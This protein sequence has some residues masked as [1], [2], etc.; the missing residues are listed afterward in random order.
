MREPEQSS[1]WRRA[2]VDRWYASQ[3]H[4]G[5]ADTD[6]EPYVEAAA[7]AAV[8]VVLEGLREIA[9]EDGNLDDGMWY[10]RFNALLETCS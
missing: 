6:P 8:R 1:E 9:A 7:D 4:V 3:D 5:Q 10:R 2:A